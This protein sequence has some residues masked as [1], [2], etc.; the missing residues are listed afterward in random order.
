MS[1]GSITFFGQRSE[2]SSTRSTT[3]GTTIPSATTRTSF[4]SR[5]TED[6][7]RLSATRNCSTRDAGTPCY[8][9]RLEN[10]PFFWW[11]GD[12]LPSKYDTSKQAAD[13]KFFDFMMSPWWAA[14]TAHNGYGT[15]NALSPEV[16]SYM[17]DEFWGWMF[18][19]KATYQPLSKIITETWGSTHP[20][21]ETMPARMQSALFTPD[22]YFPTGGTPRTGS[23]DP[24][25]VTRD[26]GSIDDKNK[27]T[28]YFLSPDYPDNPTT[29]TNLWASLKATVPA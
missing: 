26:L 16:K 3:S 7:L 15:V 12:F 27:I 10:G 19:G 25:G 1:R 8:Y 22:K 11:N 20:E 5:K 24:N 21:F 18:S 14:N 4:H 23:P 2:A 13:Y 29:Y 17:G 9:A 28:R 6:R